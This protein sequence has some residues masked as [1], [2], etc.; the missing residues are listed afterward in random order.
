MIRGKIFNTKNKRGY[1][2]LSIDYFN[3]K[4]DVIDGDT[5][6]TFD[7]E[8]VKFLESTG[9]RGDKGYIYRNDFLIARKA[10]KIVSGIVV[11]HPSGSYYLK[12]KKKND[13][14]LLRDLRID[15]FKVINLGNAA[16]HFEKMKAKKVEK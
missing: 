1:R 14:I 2:V 11:K 16:V 9:I 7:F 12:N 15:G 6:A 8:D 5:H 13:L 4:V 3:N 10:E